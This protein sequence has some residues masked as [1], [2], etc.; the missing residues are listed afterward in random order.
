MFEE[1]SEKDEEAL[2]PK[3]VAILLYSTEK[4]WKPSWQKGCVLQANVEV[5]SVGPRMTLRHILVLPAGLRKF[6]EFLQSEFSEENAFFLVECC[7]FRSLWQ[8]AD[9]RHLRPIAKALI[10]HYVQAGSTMAVNVKAEVILQVT[11]TYADKKPLQHTLLYNA[12]MEIA[13]LLGS[14]S[15][16]RFLSNVKFREFL[17]EYEAF[18]KSMEVPTRTGVISVEDL[19]SE[20]L[21]RAHAGSMSSETK[22]VSG[23]WEDDSGIKCQVCSEDFNFLRRRHHCRNCGRLVCGTCSDYKVELKVFGKAVRVC[24]RCIANSYT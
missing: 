6:T 20:F 19:Q 12:E 17:A 5:L 2:L 22:S 15:F 21:S 11:Q 24:S 4:D 7:N 13:S 16:R 10:E 18:R 3:F 1:P 8:P 9:Q 14:D 23:V